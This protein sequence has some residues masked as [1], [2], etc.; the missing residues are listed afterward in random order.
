MGSFNTKGNVKQ[1]WGKQK[2][3]KVLLKISL[4]FSLTWK[5][6]IKSA[7]IFV[8]R[9]KWQ[10]QNHIETSGNSYHIEASQLIYIANQFT[11]SV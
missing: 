2:R 11:G 3:N 9:P 5:R 6:R 7:T 1:K 10:I 8:E 4:R